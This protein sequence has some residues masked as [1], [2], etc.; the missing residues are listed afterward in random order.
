M[1]PFLIS[2]IFD[3][4]FVTSFGIQPQKYLN[5][6]LSLILGVLTFDSVYMISNDSFDCNF[7]MYMF[8]IA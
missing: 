8:A 3:Y 7:L 5:L 6:R 2:I 4:I 1:A